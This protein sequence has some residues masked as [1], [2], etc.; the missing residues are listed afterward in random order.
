MTY[1]NQIEKVLSYGNDYV[2]NTA[3]NKKKKLLRQ[4]Y[5]ELFN[6]R[7]RNC[8]TCIIEAYFKIKQ[9]TNLKTKIMTQFKLK[10]GKQIQKHGQRNVITNANLTDETA[11]DLLK[12]NKGYKK[13]FEEMPSNWLELVDGIAPK[14][15]GK[16]AEAKEDAGDQK[17]EQLDNM[18]KN[19]LVE[20]AETI[21]SLDDEMKKLKKMKLQELRDYL[22][23]VI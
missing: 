13:F 17:R 22:Y 2:N 8:S 23:N 20:M 1:G 11:I 9:L 12:S 5:Y 21:P 16:K 10:A 7:I 18:N 6:Q 15:K 3:N 4:L 14:V 19:E